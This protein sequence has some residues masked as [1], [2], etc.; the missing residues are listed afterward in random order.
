MSESLET[1]LNDWLSEEGFVVISERPKGAEF[2]LVIQNA[3]P[4][5]AITIQV[6]KLEN[7]PL[8]GVQAFMN[9]AP[10]IKQAFR[11]LEEGIKIKLLESYK[12]EMLKFEVNFRV[13]PDYMKPERFSFNYQ[14]Y[15]E[16]LTRTM[17]RNA[18]D[19]IRCAVQLIISL[20][21]LQF[22]PN[23]KWKKPKG[24]DKD[25]V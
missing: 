18:I 4:I 24:K 6:M 19:R 23:P 13:F 17:F 8:M 12:R 14:L 25:L 3:V 2:A 10:E 21:N 9:M 11:N 7:K 15:V 22:D 20:Q 16:D 5:H 1:K